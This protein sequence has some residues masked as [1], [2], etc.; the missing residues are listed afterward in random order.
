MAARNDPPAVD[1][2]GPVTAFLA[3]AELLRSPRLARLY[4]HVLRNGPVEVDAIKRELDLPH[5]TAYK[6]LGRLEELGV[7][8]RHDEA[9]P[10]TV[11]ATPVR[12]G[13]DVDGETVSVTPVLIDAIGRQLEDDDVRLYVDR[14]GVPALAAALHYARRVEDGELTQRT[15]ANRL[16]VHPVEG[17][18][19]LSALRDVLEEFAG[20]ETAPTETEE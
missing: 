8:T 7:L 11:T 16:D 4:A 9:R 3:V 1:P 17:L 2:S 18:T 5:S 12:V 10:T 13:L 6:Y 15:A 20:A 14:H 19:A